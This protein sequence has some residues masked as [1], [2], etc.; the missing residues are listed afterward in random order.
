M[1]IGIG[2]VVDTESE[3]CCGWAVDVDVDTERQVSVSTLAGPWSLER[4][5]EQAV[6]R[7]G[8]C[9]TEVDAMWGCGG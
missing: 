2:N 5:V 4:E 9:F 6:T 7:C 1:S 8:A 3:P